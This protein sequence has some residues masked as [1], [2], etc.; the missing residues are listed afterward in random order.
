MKILLLAENWEP[1]IGGI[2]RYLLGITQALVEAGHEVWVIAPKMK[3]MKSGEVGYRVIRK[4]FYRIYTRPRWLRLFKY[5][6]GLQEKENFD[7]VLAGKCLFE[8]LAAWRLYKQ[9][10]VPYMVFT[11]GMEIEEWASKWRL[12][13]RMRKVAREA[14]KIFYINAETQRKLQEIGVGK[15]K[16]HHLPPGIDGFWLGEVSSDEVRRITDT[17][18]IK[19]PYIITVARLIKRKGVDDLIQAFGK[20][21]QV[22]FENVMLVI[23]GEGPE[24]GSLGRLVERDMLGDSVAFVGGAS[25][26]ELR[27]LYAGAEFFAMTPR[28][29]GNDMEGFGIVYLEAA[30]QGKPAVATNSG[31]A[32]EAV[33]NG[34]TGLVVKEG[35]I[36]AIAGAL[37]KMLSEKVFRERLGVGARDMVRKEYD[38]SQRI[39]ELTGD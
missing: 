9:L 18:E 38:W 21:D 2:E 25:D 6:A 16:L 20:I 28:R 31:G 4:K 27:A 12:R 1:R 17:C 32:G 34:V 36:A 24:E 29:L 8:G 11:Y 13:L 3:G 10:G 23:V 39:G 30:A 7:L 14:K 26:E 22:K 15:D 5:L 35:D 37:E 33:V 19:A